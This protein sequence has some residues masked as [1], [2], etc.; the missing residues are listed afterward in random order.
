MDRPEAAFGNYDPM[1]G[2][3]QTHPVSDRFGEAETRRLYEVVNSDRFRAELAEFNCGD[4]LKPFHFSVAFYEAGEY[5]DRYVVYSPYPEIGTS[6]R[7]R[8][9]SSGMS[10]LWDRTA[11]QL[12]RGQIHNPGYTHPSGR[13][14]S[15][16]EY[17]LRPLPRP[18]CDCT[19]RDSNEEWVFWDVG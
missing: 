13:V 9:L 19:K 5:N 10:Y 11:R 6:G 3:G 7:D 4:P 16:E 8:C 17:R 15:D 2:G 1:R 18:R 12:D 14:I